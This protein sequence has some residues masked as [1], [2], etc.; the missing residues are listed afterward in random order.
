MDF[1]QRLDRYISQN[2]PNS[3]L[4]GQLFMQLA[5]GNERLAGALAVIAHKESS[6][7]TTN[8]RYRNNAWGW[9]V[10]LGPGVHSGNSWEE[11]GQRVVRGLQ[12]PLY[13][14]SG[15]TRLRDII[16]KYAPPNEN[17]TELYKRQTDE[18]M[19][20]LGLNPD[21]S[22]FDGSTGAS[23]DTSSEGLVNA[24]QRRLNSPTAAASA[25]TPPGADPMTS[26]LVSSIAQRKP[27]E[28]LFQSMKQ[29]M[30]TG[31]MQQAMQPPPAPAEQGQSTTPGKDPHAGHNHAPGQHGAGTE[32]AGGEQTD[33]ASSGNVVAILPSKPNFGGYGYSDPEGQGGRHLATD[34]FAPVGT[35]VASPVH[36]RIVRLTPDPNPGQRASGQ[37]FGGTLGIR[38]NDG[39]LWVMRHIVPGSFKVGQQV[40]AGQRVGS[41]K[42]WGSGSHIHLEAYKRGSG[43]REYSPGMALNPG[44][45]YRAAGL[46]R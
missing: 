32:G 29:G 30:L 9:G 15:L 12:G 1:T 2:A 8:G 17:D 41:V 21:E 43:D 14:G 42:D 4:S 34:W 35:P 3:P 44:D 40:T 7:G 16:Q 37:V 10:H 36:G 27:G 26:S 38:D 11:V 23:S 6:F 25:S 5:N 19:L 45:I 13:K 28:S 18:R 20:A 33:Y 24:A 22:I 46:Y 31:A 39:R